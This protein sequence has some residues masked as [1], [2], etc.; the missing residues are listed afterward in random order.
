MHHEKK[1]VE[2]LVE[3]LSQR[4]RELPCNTVEERRIYDRNLRSLR[5]AQDAL[6]EFGTT[7]EQLID[8]LQRIKPRRRKLDGGTS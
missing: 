1:A 3:S 2:E 4:V 6:D 5:R 8:L 7:P